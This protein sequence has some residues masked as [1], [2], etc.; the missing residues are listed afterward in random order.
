MFSQHA[1][2]INIMMNRLLRQMIL[3]QCHGDFSFFQG[4]SGNLDLK[5][6]GVLS[7]GSFVGALAGAPGRTWHRCLCRKQ[8]CNE[9]QPDAA[10]TDRGC[11]FDCDRVH[12]T[13]SLIE[14]LECV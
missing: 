13:L 3:L 9:N 14:K 7:A 8:K 10:E 4:K 2:I 6:A 12:Q 1:L 5:T 11:G